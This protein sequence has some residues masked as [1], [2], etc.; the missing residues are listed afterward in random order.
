[1]SLKPNISLIIL[2]PH[3]QHLNI[4]AMFK[5]IEWYTPGTISIPCIHL[6]NLYNNLLL[7]VNVTAFVAEQQLM[8]SMTMSYNSLVF[9]VFP[10]HLDQ[11]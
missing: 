10:G 6:A 8:G 2:H 3:K 4:Q 9:L 1:M 5:T 7:F 11:H